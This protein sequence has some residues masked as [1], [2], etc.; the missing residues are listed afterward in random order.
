[1]ILFSI[2]KCVVQRGG[3]TRYSAVA[4]C[5][6]RC[7][8]SA[9]TAATTAATVEPQ[10]T[11]RRQSAQFT[12]VHCIDTLTMTMAMRNKF[13]CDRINVGERCEVPLEQFEQL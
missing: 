6:P 11:T 10:L 3:I 8:G 9:E 2:I 13:C 12:I 1:M 5:R 4:L 7:Y